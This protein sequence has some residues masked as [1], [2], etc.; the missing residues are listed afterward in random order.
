MDQASPAAVR[1]DPA[2]RAFFNHSRGLR[3]NTDAVIAQILNEKFE[4]LELVIAPKMTSD[5][6]GFASSGNAS[7]Q[8]LDEKSM[9]SGSDALSPPSLISVPNSL[10]WIV[11]R[12]P[13]R[14]VDGDAGSLAKQ[15][16]FSGFSYQWGGKSFIVYVVDGRDGTQAY[17]TVLNQYILCDQRSDA[18]ALIAEAGR[19]SSALHGEVWVFDGGFW[20]KSAE[21]YDSV[22]RSSWDDVILDDD[23]KRSLIGD[24]I[25]FFE[26]K[27]EYR[28][29]RVPWKRGIIYYGPPGNGK[30]ISIKAMMHML[31]QRTPEV[32]TLYVRTLASVSD[33]IYISP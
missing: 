21:L 2:A 1:E 23:M 22:Q 24:H 3:V 6:L 28:Q 15:I 7:F 10:E 33:S 19:W 4:K 27:E 26:S 17:P 20:Q 32:P 18:L 16:I 30:T 25:T 14:R 12:P 5:L 29:L 31:Y 9:S 11:Y 8:P 13:A